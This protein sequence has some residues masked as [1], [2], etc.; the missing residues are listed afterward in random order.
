MKLIHIT[1][2]NYRSLLDADFDVSPYTLLVGANNSGK[3]TILDA[4][5]TFYCKDG[6]KFDGKRDFPF[7]EAKD[8]ESWVE[9]SFSLSDEEYDSLADK[10]KSASRILKARKYFQT[11]EKQD[12][13]KT[14]KAG[15]IFAYNNTAQ[16]EGEPFYGANNVQSGKFGDV[17]FI[18][19]VSKVDEHT[20][21]SGPSA[22]RDLITD[23]M[24]TISAGSDAFAQFQTQF[25][26]FASKIKTEQTGGGRS[27]STFEAE[28]NSILSGWGA[29]F[30][31]KI[32]P[33]TA[34]E[35]VKSLVEPI[36]KDQRF[37]REQKVDS[38]GSGFQRYF[39]Y[40]LIEISARY[41]TKAP[42]KKAKDFTP[43][44]TLLLFEEPEAFLHPPQQENLA[45]NLKGITATET[46]QVICSTHSS[47]FVSRRTEDLLGIVRT[48]AT[49]KGSHVHQLTQKL[50]DEM[51]VDNQAI[52]TILGAE[53]AD[54]T[55][56][57]EAVK[58]F[59][60]LNP[61]RASAFFA[62]HVLIMEGPTEV[63]LVRRLM[64]DAR[65]NAGTG[66]IHP[67]ELDRKV[68]HP[69]IH[70]PPLCD[71]DS[72]QRHL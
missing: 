24:T 49:G 27:L 16:I 63:A 35:I 1:L 67:L 60:W 71:G 7:A 32:N 10:Y 36:W 72:A 2:H 23:I 5:R 53:A 50:W 62:D 52:N 14:S 45:R 9:L 29:D 17:I 61:D 55:D 20:K 42:K 58:H 51:V 4:L 64:D 39:I 48:R 59:L 54:Y 25:D 37:D 18:P 21:L 3:S 30:S 44:M 57:M 33:P 28:F 6:Y 19:A 22:L 26:E 47:H 8:N 69:S 11:S 65:I 41:S 43:E 66:G 15:V 34:A 38:F 40:S 56:E 12:D 31:L 46:H 13:G 68:Q 70:E